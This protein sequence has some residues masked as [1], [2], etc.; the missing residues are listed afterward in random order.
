M[1]SIN[2]IVMILVLFILS[3]LLVSCDDDNSS[4]DEDDDTTPCAGCLIDDV[5]YE[6]NETNPDN[7]CQIC[8]VS[9]STDSWADNDYATCLDGLFCNGTDACMNGTCSEHAGDPCK[10]YE[11]CNET[12]GDCYD[13]QVETF[14]PSGSFWMGCELE[15]TNCKPDESPRHEVTLSA[16]YIDIYEVTN[17][18]YAKFLNDH[19]NDCDGHECVDAGSLYIKVHESGGIWTAEPGFEDHPMTYVSWYGTKDFCEW[20]GG[21]LPT[22]AQWEKA[23]KGAAEHYIWPWGDTW[24]DN[25]AN[26]AHNNDPWENTGDHPPTSPVGYYDGSSHGGAYQTSDGRSP[27]GV[28]DMAGNV[29]EWVNDWYDEDYYSVS[30]STNPPGPTQGKYRVFRGG[31]WYDV[32]DYVRTSIRFSKGY[33][34][35]SIDLVGFRC[36]R[37]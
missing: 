10:T 19:G 8:N 5:C 13:P 22:E 25:A 36:S 21:R 26:W 7:V 20:S 9:Q 11:T 3:F 15:D 18:R 31:S 2:M 35:Y 1:R 34:Y 16:Y 29:W 4:G 6:V 27:Y 17:E 30:P 14:I 24:I 28:H 37:D 23:A 32:A 12:M 33:P